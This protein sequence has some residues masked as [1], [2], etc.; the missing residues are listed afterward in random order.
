[1]KRVIATAMHAKSENLSAV[2]HQLCGAI[3]LMHIQIDDQNFTTQL[4]FE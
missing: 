2:F 1:M 4:L 3:T